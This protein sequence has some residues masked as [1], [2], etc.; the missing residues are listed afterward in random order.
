M[1]LE[2]IIQSEISQTGK[3]KNTVSYH[4]YVESEK[5]WYRQSYLQSRNRD[6]DLQNKMD[7]KGEEGGGMN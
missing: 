6:T 5:K 1:D 4:I 3:K 7:T 2:T